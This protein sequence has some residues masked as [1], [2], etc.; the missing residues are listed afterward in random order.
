MEFMGVKKMSEY[1]ECP[2][3]VAIIIIVAITIYTLECPK[4]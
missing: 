4:I 3:I 2:V 1:G